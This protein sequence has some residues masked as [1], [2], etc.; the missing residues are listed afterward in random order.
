[1]RKTTLLAIVILL[2]I[3]AS[4]RLEGFIH[5][6]IWQEFG[7]SDKPANTLNVNVTKEEYKLILQK[8]RESQKCN[9]RIHIYGLSHMI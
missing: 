3:V 1:M 9:C 6:K 2:G 5:D 8:R 4:Y 7:A